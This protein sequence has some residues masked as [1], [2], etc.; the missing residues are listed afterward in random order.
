M[1]IQHRRGN[2]S[3][4]DPAKMLPGEMAVV[5]SGDPNSKT[6]RSVYICFE[7]GVVKRFTTYE[8]FESEILNATQDIRSDFLENI[9]NATQAANNAANA[10]NTSKGLAD[11]AAE[12]ANAAAAACEGIIDNTRMTAVEEKIESIIETLKNVISDEPQTT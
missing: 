7:A 1:A 2:Y 11:N 12:R 10:A 8:D 5:L 9:T 3:Q 4:F 6:G